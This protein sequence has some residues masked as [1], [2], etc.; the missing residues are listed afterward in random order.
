MQISGSM[1]T[2]HY[3]LND[4]RTFMARRSGVHSLAAKLIDM[5]IAFADKYAVSVAQVWRRVV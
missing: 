2:S 3:L 1:R 5:L 4:H